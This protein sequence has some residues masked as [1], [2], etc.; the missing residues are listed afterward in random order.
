MSARFA[1]AAAVM[2]MALST[3][4]GRITAAENAY[5][6]SHGLGIVQSGQ[7][8][9]RVVTWFS[10]NQTMDGYVA[11][12][13]KGAKPTAAVIIFTDIYGF[14]LNNTRL[15]A[16]RLAA[17]GGFLVIVP[18]FFRGD[19]VTEAT[20]P[21]MAEWRLRHPRERVL[22]DFEAIVAEV[23][24]TNPAITK[25]FQQGF[26]WG[27]LYSGLLSGPTAPKV[28]AAV[29]F[30][31]SGLTPEI[32][33]AVAGPISLQQ[34]DPTLDNA[35]NVTFYDY[36]NTTFAAKRAEGIHAYA[37]YYPN[38]PHGFALR[39]NL[40]DPA[41]LK[42]STT[43]FNEGV[44]FLKKHVAPAHSAADH[45]AM[46]AKGAKAGA[47]KGAAP[48]GVATKAMPGMGGMAMP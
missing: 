40:S 43:A 30:H 10:G 5:W 42:A 25:I 41:W 37:T 44:A 45:A 4:H 18:D 22:D 2:C 47:A 11:A 31:T 3:A 26:C 32:I 46:M 48:K 9:G 28:D 24:R 35:V 21:M 15:W 34:A 20:R 6:A 13:P 17:A 12:P 19:P 33:D 27:G 39:G 36:I 29:G 23:K 14:T 7:Q 16:D 1:I 38:M 8:A